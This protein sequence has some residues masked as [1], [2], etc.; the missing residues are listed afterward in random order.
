MG[1]ILG[2]VKISCNGCGRYGAVSLTSLY[3][4]ESHIMAKETTCPFCSG[5]L[6]KSTP[7][8]S[9]IQTWANMIEPGIAVPI[10]LKS[11]LRMQNHTQEKGAKNA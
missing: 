9:E 6:E 1:N 7:T 2:W 5:E 4:L 3:P 10:T 8:Q 11:V